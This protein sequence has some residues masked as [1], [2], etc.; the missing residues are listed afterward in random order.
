VIG[1]TH[2]SAT[3]ERRME[4]VHDRRR[5]SRGGR[6]D[7]DP[8]TN[9]RRVAWLFAAYAAYVSIRSLPANVKTFFRRARQRTDR[10]AE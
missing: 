5:H 4:Q 3:A 6:R 1:V 9:W 10:I 8:R 7:N 2:S